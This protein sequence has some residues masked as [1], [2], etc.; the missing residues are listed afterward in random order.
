MS[1]TK[2]K[3][4]KTVHLT[5]L[6][7]AR[8]KLDGI[9][10]ETT[11]D[12]NG[13]KKYMNMIDEKYAKVLAD[14]EK[15]QDAYT[16]DQINLLEI[17][18]NDM[19]KL[20]DEILDIKFRAEQLL[21]KKDTKKDAL[22]ET[23][24]LIEKIKEESLIN[25][26][27]RSLL[28]TIQLPRFDGSIVKYEEFMD[29][30]EAIVKNNPNIEDVEK[31]IF[32]KAHLDPP[33]SDLLEGFSTTNSEYPAA[34]EL[35][36]ETYGNKSL[37]SKI[38]IS[39]L[40]SIEKHDG[41]SS[42]RATYNQLRTCIRRL[43]SLGMKS[44]DFS[45]FLI[46]IC[47]SK[48]NRD[49]NKKWYRKNDESIENLLKFIQEEVESTEGAMHIED[50]FSSGPSKKENTDQ[51][52]YQ[53]Y[54][55]QKT[56]YKDT[57]SQ[58]QDSKYNKYQF[59]P[60]S[61]TALHAN[62]QKYYCYHCKQDSHDTQNCRNLEKMSS[63]DVRN[64]LNNNQ[65]CY[66]C[67]R[68]NHT[69][70]KCFH[71]S[72]LCC[73]KCK[74][75]THHTYLHEDRRNRSKSSERR[76]VQNSSQSV[77]KTTVSAVSPVH[78]VI[79]QTA[80]AYLKNSKHCRHK[81]KVVFDSCSDHSFITTD[82]CNKVE[83]K[84]HEEIL[85]IGG[86]NGRSDG[87]K[88]YKVRHAVIQSILHHEKSRSV[89]LVETDVICS[90]IHREA[91]SNHVLEFSYLQGIDLAEDYSST[92][93]DTID[94]LI[95]LDFYW[96]FVTGKTRRKPN[97]PIA[98]ESILGWMLQANNENNQR[99]ATPAN[100]NQ[101]CQSTTLFITSQEGKEIHNQL[102][103]FWEL[104]EVEK[105]NDQKWTSEEIK[106]N[107]KFESTIVH[108]EN[109]Q[110]QAR[111]PTKDD[112]KELCS[113]K[114]G[115][116]ERN[117]SLMKRLSKNPELGEKY[118]SAMKEFVENGFAEVVN[119]NVEPE[120]CFYSPH[121]PVIKEDSLTTKVR[122]VFE[123]NAS[124]PCSKSLND[125]LFKGPTLQPLLN[126]VL[127]RFRMKPIAYTS[128][129]M[130]MFLMVG[131]HPDDRDYLRFIWEDP[132]DKS[133]AVYR[134]KV[135]PF[136]L[137]CSSY[138]AIATV[139]HHVNKYK[140]EYPKIV[141]ELKENVYVDDLLTGS[142]TLEE[143]LSDYEAE[144]NIMKEGGMKLRKWTSN[145]AELNERFKADQ[146]ASPD[147]QK[148]IT[149]EK[150]VLGVTWNNS[151]DYF[152]FHEKG[153]LNAS[154]DIRPTKRNLLS[155]AGK[156]YDPSGW[157]APYIIIMKIFMQ[158]LWER[159]LEWD[160][161]IPEDIGK[162][163][164]QWKEDLKLLSE[165]KIPRYIGNVHRKPV[166]PI[167]LHT[168]ADAS[169][170]AYAAVSYLKS[171]NEDG[172][173]YVTQ[174]F[175]RTKVC[176]VKKVSIPRLELLAAV[177]AAR[178]ATYVMK[179]L[180]LPDLQ[181]YM[182]TDAMVTLYW[183]KGNSRNY[184]TFVANRIE[185]IHELTEPEYW[186][187]CP[188][189]QN[190][191]DIPSRGLLLNQLI[192]NELWWSGPIWL[193]HSNET[194]PNHYEDLKNTD[195]VKREQ[196]NR[197]QVC[198]LTF[199]ETSNTSTKGMVMK[200]IDFK[201]YSTYKRLLF[202]TACI[203]RYL[204]NLRSKPNDRMK[205]DINATDMKEAEV[206]WLKFIQQNSFPEELENLRNAKSV[207]STSKL[208][209]F[210]PYYDEADGII[211]MSGRLEFSD[212]Q[213][214]EKH[215]IILPRNSYLVK[216]L[217]EDIHVRQLHSGIN[218]TII[219]VREKY[220]VIQ[221]RTLVKRIVKGCIT[222]R[223][224]APVRLQIQMAPLPKDRIVQ[225]LPFNVVGVDFTG[226]LYVYIE[227]PNIKYEK[228]L[229]MKVASYDG[230]KCNKM[231][232]CLFTCAVTR[233][234]HLE[235]VWDLTTESFVNAFRRFI[236]TRGNCNTIYSDNALT[237][238]KAEKDLKFYLEL[239]NGKAF[240]NYVT[241][242]KL[243][244][245][246]ILEYAPW[247]GGFY[248]RL[249]KSIKQPL[250]KILGRSRMDADEMNTILKEIEAQ[251]NSRPLTTVYDDDAPSGRNYITPACFLVGKRIMNIPLEPREKIKPKSDQKIL[252]QILKQQNKYLDSIWKNF[253]EEYSR[254]LGTVNNKV[255]SPDCIKVGE[256]VM[257]AQ[258]SL[259]RTVWNVGV[260]ENLK[261]GRD[262]R[263]RTVYVRTNNEVVPRAIQH[264]SR[265]EA[266]SLEE[267]QQ[268]QC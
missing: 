232:I 77:V 58:K 215:P 243:E 10:R 68:K 49:M 86:Y 94:V 114:A 219:S 204:Y 102:K 67:F 250:K 168:F 173:V 166:T 241:E 227:K 160:E 178:T 82:A 99:N 45:L 100:S 121:H 251:I 209:K 97:K 110:Y 187:W 9:L 197:N 252:N 13:I 230:I 105:G 61:G 107:N 60:S 141:K 140:N 83:L 162:Q 180:N 198:L 6:N 225:S 129:V 246:Y 268:F 59:K 81:I 233:A 69:T 149:N 22:N 218:Q 195:V 265:L 259:P 258:P 212:F 193:K 188:G 165:I 239:M 30:F 33:A 106:V 12:E 91:V 229:K 104:E 264:I 226:P 186:R 240:Q 262:G 96:S 132:Q 267:F 24:G 260:I 117:K 147:E 85:D 237:F 177:L 183:I 208:S 255:N 18:I 20:A 34:L 244:W 1:T 249:M 36:K 28:P 135:L 109:G 139:H 191:A 157:L 176:P 175:A 245:K 73:R 257:I 7:R 152:T 199:T 2:L 266:D 23:L 40:L 80:N 47:L 205:G 153:N 171:I 253:R 202:I 127:M 136:G 39:K 87:M 137:T 70:A 90:N 31:F 48:L 238:K 19:D 123:G 134:L 27:Q 3:A 29:S 66:C 247:W 112:I 194:Y 115:A 263:I 214:D 224:I 122:P 88:R 64:F 192:K 116:I 53:K 21:I 210:N 185:L 213:F 113:N 75:H 44:E 42:M 92:S 50:A 4:T 74:S 145:N 111:L 41:K 124:A 172:D 119:E 51:R 156:L 196:K 128:D 5:H 150:S 62:T 217:V 84:Y 108:E 56:V 164:F 201:K 142:Y 190:P 125:Y 78:N 181:I 216:L 71:R 76:A 170:N 55:S 89:N 206:T 223:K 8:N 35:L 101:R 220:W 148:T 95:G 146:V 54:N 63:S 174:M 98:V 38:C 158:Q 131:I 167:E 57:Y 65:L 118:R 161:I 15:L 126:E 207:K 32:L 254:N 138:I 11:I 159:G 200:L 79:F 26:R 236:S 14:S 234:V 120:S 151:E 248:E 242:Q 261:E 169:E 222:C 93:D 235:L 189:E 231:Y 221:L 25:S 52:R 228:S 130:K 17:E 163:W 144:I 256:L 203:H 143:A 179:T 43:E 46:P 16:D 184:K 211:R 155:V 103:R 133:M 37:L 72:S 154:T 182:W